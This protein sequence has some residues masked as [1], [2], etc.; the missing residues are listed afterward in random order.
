M[1]FNKTNIYEHSYVPDLGL[2][3]SINKSVPLNR[4]EDGSGGET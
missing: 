4:S 1:L 3:I 2:D